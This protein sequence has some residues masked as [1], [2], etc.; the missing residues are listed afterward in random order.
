MVVSSAAHWRAVLAEVDQ[1][2]LCAHPIRLRGISLDR[3]TGELAERDLLVPCKDRRAAV[4]RACSRLYQADAWQLVAA[5]LRGGKGV[6]AAVVSHPQLF[7]TLTAP[8]FGP[9][10]SR[11]LNGDRVL[12]CRP[13]R[14]ERRCPH[15]RSMSCL[16]RHGQDAIL[17]GDPLCARCFDYRGSVLWNAHVPRLW[18]RT[19]MRLYRAVARAGGL[20]TTQ[21]RARARLSY[22]K[23]VEFQRRGLVHLHVVLRA[24][25]AGGPADLPPPWLG[26]ATL[27]KAVNEAV[28]G[29]GIALPRV[30]GLELARACWG[31]QVDV[32]VLESTEP[33]DAIAI[34]AY[35]AKYAT[36][37][38]DGTA[39]L[40]HPLRSAAQIERLELRPHVVELVRTAWRLA[41]RK[42][43]AHLALHAHAHTLGYGGQFSSKSLRFSTTFTALRA[44][45]A[46]FAAG[47]DNNDGADED[48]EGAWRFVGRGYGDPLAAELAERLAAAS[49]G[50]RRRVPRTVPGVVPTSTPVR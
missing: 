44:A 9:V 32:R 38:A 20:S 2:G 4:C 27:T 40:A 28:A 29:S 25:G 19:S 36:K 46:A 17:L 49:R 50:G 33:D 30:S 16:E 45:R 31:A 18:E 5:G 47:E 24:D 34:A 1:A 14:S 35:V 22:L 6:D 8:S 21:L 43:L 7:V 3:R 42:E 13:R 41:A 15:G 12:P 23:V 37:T 48:Y 26:A 11:S 39:W 10:H